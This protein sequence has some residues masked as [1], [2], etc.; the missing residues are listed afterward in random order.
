M[1]VNT[2]KKAVSATTC[3]ESPL[4]L[5]SI[6]E[7]AGAL[8]RL[9]WPCSDEI[10][11]PATPLLRAAVEQLTAYFAGEL[12]SFALPLKPKGSPFEQAV[13]AEMLAIPLGET[14]SYGEIAK[15]LGSAAQPVGNACGANPIPI[16]IPCHRILGA[17]GLGGF[18]ASGGVEDKVW[19]LRHEGAAGLLI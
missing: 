18:S 10:N 11:L 1:T 19:L 17:S 16:L 15:A 8:T 14:R 7:D 3:I 2:D 4:G 9:T 12:T 13:W 5:I 6:C